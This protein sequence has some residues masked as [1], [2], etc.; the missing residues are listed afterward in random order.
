MFDKKKVINYDTLEYTGDPRLD[1]QINLLRN[2]RKFDN[3][4]TRLS[5]IVLDLEKFKNYPGVTPGTIIHSK[6]S[7]R[8]IVTAEIKNQNLVKF[9][10]QE[11][12][13]SI[14]GAA[15]IGPADQ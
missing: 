5:A 2:S 9:T 8:W 12:V 14:S 1:F 6:Y 11:W 3:G 13:K 4:S 10:H 7:N 15:P